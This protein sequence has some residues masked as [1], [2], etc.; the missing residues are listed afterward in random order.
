MANTGMNENETEICSVGGTETR[1]MPEE[2]RGSDPRK[3]GPFFPSQP[4]SPTDPGG[5]RG[6]IGLD[7][8]TGLPQKVSKETPALKRLN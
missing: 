8:E 1:G 3:K 6:S 2:N 4:P 7:K 5:S